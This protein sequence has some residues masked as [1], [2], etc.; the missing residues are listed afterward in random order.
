MRIREAIFS[1][2]SGSRSSWAI[3]CLCA[4][5]LSACAGT[6][7]VRADRNGLFDSE[8][9][10]AP[11]RTARGRKAVGTPLKP[12]EIAQVRAMT[13]DWVWPLRDMKVTSTFGPRSGSMHEGT[14]F[15]ARTGT[16]IYAVGPGTV[17]YAGAR[18]S[19]YGKMVVLKHGNG[20]STVYAHNSKLFVKQGQRIQTGQKIAN[21]GNTGRSS[22]PHL[23]FEVRKGVT[24]LNPADFLPDRRTVLANLAKIQRSRP[25]AGR[26]LA[27]ESRRPQVRTSQSAPK[28]APVAKKP[29][30]KASVKQ[31]NSKKQVAKKRPATRPARV[32]QNRQNLKTDSSA[33]PGT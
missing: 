15:R 3:L 30:R 8:G 6:R 26:S 13:R 10:A 16:P 24:A 22:G 32:S 28:R 21:A 14:D 7:S 17:A 11:S 5:T 29:V 2:S 31:K 12:L 20:V 1:R 19:G 33:R 27:S 25:T 4:L 23:H 18:I 9:S